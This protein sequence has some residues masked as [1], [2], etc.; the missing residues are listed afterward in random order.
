MNEAAPAHAVHLL[1]KDEDERVRVLIAR[2]LAALAPGLSDHEQERLRQ[3]TYEALAGLVADEA[4]RVRAAL[5]DVLKE[6][7]DAPRELILAARARP[8]AA[9]RRAGDPLLAAAHRAGLA[10]AADQRPPPCH[11][12]LRRAPP[13]SQRGGLR[14]HRGDRQR[15]GDP[16]A[17]DQPIRRD[18][19]GDAGRA[20]RQRRRAHGVARA[21]GPPPDAARRRRAQALRDRREP[22]A[23]GSGQPRRP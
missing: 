17:A 15:L 2:K 6:M 12:H 9:G 1:A 14:Q 20:D 8:R 10:G 21:P 22:P 23:R 4:V 18:P 5:A 11:R 13:A 16:R 19:R 7:P 3:Q